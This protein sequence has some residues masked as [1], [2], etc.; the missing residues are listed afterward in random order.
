MNKEMGWVG[1]IFLVMFGHTFAALLLA[2]V[3]I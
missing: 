1:V 2:L 3:V